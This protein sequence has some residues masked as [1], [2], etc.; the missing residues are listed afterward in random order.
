MEKTSVFMGEK[1]LEIEAENQLFELKVNDVYLWQY[2][3]YV[4]LTKILEEIT[5]VETVN[6]TGR[7]L[8][9]NK[10]KKR[11]LWERLKRQQFLVFPKDILVIN[12]PRRVKDGKYYK[13]FVTD[14]ILENIKYSYYVYESEYYGEH[15]GPTKTRNLKYIDTKIFERFLNLDEERYSQDIRVF[16]KKIVNTFEQNCH[17]NMST[18]LKKDILWYVSE[19]YINVCC[20]KI[21]ARTILKLVH[22]KTVLLTVGYSPLVQCIISEAKKSGIPTIELQHGRIGN[23]HIAYNYLY[24]GEIETFADYMFVYGDYEKEIPRYPIDDSHVIAV[25]YPELEEKAKYYAN[26]KK[27]K[28]KRVITFISGPG[29]GIIVSKYAIELRQN[30]RF[31]DMKMIYKLHPS[32]YECWHKW[33]PHLIGSGLE[34]VKDN[35]HDIYYYIGHSDYVVG[36]S[37]TVLFEATEFDT[38]IF[39]IK[40]QDYRKS[41]ILYKNKLA[42]L[43]DN[44]DELIIEINQET[45]EQ[46]TTKVNGYFKK[47]AVRNIQRQL[48]KII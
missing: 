44:I 27:R 35:T 39:I 21:W 43:I 4:C 37:S 12:H 30:P 23:T 25:G 5:G 1:L 7:A 45:V 46:N 17:I 20:Y 6:R 29:D 16:S 2:V 42:S 9:Y 3:R 19:T 33:Y 31:K 8:Q 14:R 11:G 28:G 22:P 36:I 48:N 10:K 47:N 26:V 41:E 18:Q 24:S 13:C 34:I 40:A 32:E 38:R 15:V